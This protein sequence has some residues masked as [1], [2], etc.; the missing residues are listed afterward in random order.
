RRARF[1]GEGQ[2]IGTDRRR[3]AP[4]RRV[5][6]K[7]RHRARVAVAA[8]ALALGGAAAAVSQPMNMSATS[9]LA[10]RLEPPNVG[11]P[12]K[13]T[14][15]GTGVFVLAADGNRLTLTYR[16]TYASLSDPN[17]RS[18]AFRTFRAGQ[19]GP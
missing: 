15:S 9:F 3:A 12:S 1:T 17:G 19:E 4:L 8:A 2:M 6:A 13:S 16:L 7:G 5:A 18:L 14:G 10:A 11:P